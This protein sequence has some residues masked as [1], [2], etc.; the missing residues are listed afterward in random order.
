MI[1]LFEACLRDESLF[2]PRCC[3]KR[4][5]FS[6]VKRH[7]SPDLRVEFKEKAKEYETTDRVYCAV[8]RCSRF[9]GPR[10]EGKSSVAAKTY[11]CQCGEITCSRCKNAC[12][13]GIKHS[14]SDSADEG[15]ETV[16]TLGRAQGWA[17]CPGCRTMIELNMG[18][19]HM[20]CLCKVTAY[21]L[22]TANLLIC[23]SG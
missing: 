4:I 13:T 18:C 10:V 9:L 20:T 7:F 6:S 11:K 8:P 23:A 15:A 22:C 1:S 21:P 19:H 3:R 14:C 17:R 5:P 12:P 2:H 16:L